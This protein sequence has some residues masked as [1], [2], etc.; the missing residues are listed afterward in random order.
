MSWRALTESDLL[1][2]L[3]QTELDTFREVARD[4]TSDDPVAPV[5]EQV[6][7]EVR[8]YI[9]ACPQ[10]SLGLD[11]TLPDSLIRSAVALA[12]MQIMSRAAGQIMDPD[13]ER[14]GRADDAVALLNRV[15]DCKFG[16]EHP[17]TIETGESSAGI[18]IVK[19]N[20][21]CRITGDSLDGLY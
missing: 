4:G 3:S 21:K 5:L 10:N 8:G 13:D 11:G 15:A 12:I 17:T 1:T 2:Q 18:S 16:I 20:N 9:R 14:Q 6:T 19:K 7:D